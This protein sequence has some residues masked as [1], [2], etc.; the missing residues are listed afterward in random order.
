MSVFGK[1]NFQGKQSAF[2][3]TKRKLLNWTEYEIARGARIVGP[4]GWHRKLKI[5]EDW[6]IGNNCRIN[7]NGTV[8]IR[9]LDDDSSKIAEE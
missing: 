9:R 5:G 4:V 6:K 1:Y 3:E 8:F 2:F 7:G